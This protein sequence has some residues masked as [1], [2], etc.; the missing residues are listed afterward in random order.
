MYNIQTN[1]V[2]DALN[3][4]KVGLSRDEVK[5][6]QEKNGKNKIDEPK[7]KS[8]LVRFL[9]QFT[10]III[11]VLL[12][13]CVLSVA[14]CIINKDP[15]QLFDAGVILLV[16]IVNAVIGYVQEERA[17]R[18][19]DSLKD[20][21]KPYCKV[22]RDGVVKKIKTEDLV[23]GDVVVLEAGD[24]VPADM[25][26]F[27][28][29][30]LRCNESA[31]TGESMP[32]E[33]H[34]DV[35]LKD[36]V[37]LGDR[38][39]MA[40]MGTSVT[41][42]RGKGVVVAT[43][44]NTEMGKIAD[45]INEQVPQVSPITRRIKKTN[46]YITAFVLVM[47][48]IIFGF[49]IF[50][51]RLS[52]SGAFMMAIAIAVCVIP[53]G[54]PASITVTL[55]IGVSRMSKRKAIV[56]HTPAVETLGSTQ[57][58]CTDKT[59]T[60]TLNEMTVTQIYTLNNAVNKLQSTSE[61]I[62][63]SKSTDISESKKV[64]NL[65]NSQ[66]QN[67]VQ[68]LNSM[69]LCNDTQC[70]Y[71]AGNLVTIGDPTETA[72]VHYGYGLGLNKEVYDAT[73]PRVD[74]V[75]FDSNRKL[76]STINKHDNLYY[77]HT[78]GGVDRLLPICNR[79]LDETGVVRNITASDI[80][81]I[82]KA[83]VDMANDALRVLGFAYREISEDYA[84]MADSDIESNLIFVGLCGMIDP[85][86]AEVADAIK[87]C[88]RAGI[89]T[90]M[91]TGDHKDTAFAIAKK[92]GMATDERQVISGIELDN[93][94]DDEFMVAVKKYTVF[95]RVTPEHKLKIVRAL[96]AQDKIVAMTGDGVNDAPSIKE[97]DIGIGMGITGTD[98]T[99]DV[100]DVILTDDNFAT[101]VSAVEEGRRVYSNIL[102]ILIFLIGTSVA[103]A[104]LLTTIMV[105]MRQDFFTPALI[106][107]INFI[108]DTL[109][110]LALSAEN[111][112]P[113]IMRQKPERHRKSLF[114]GRV[115]V[116]ILYSAL[117]SSIINFAVYFMGLHVF[118]FSHDV[119]ITMCFVTLVFTELFHA[120]NLR[121]DHESVF[122]I[123]VFKNKYMNISFL[124]SATLTTLTVVLPMTTVHAFLGVTQLNIAQWGISLLFAFS[125]VPLMELSKF[126]TYVIKL[127]KANRKPK[128]I[129][130]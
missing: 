71:D 84:N 78:K 96:K 100:A 113:D 24:V 83:N 75:P 19:M 27:E 20:L 108:S 77:V 111:S 18:A 59:G 105:F 7:K 95:A 109:V 130:K 6:R 94:N 116:I 47:A 49:G 90:I 69:L 81:K 45:V 42:G 32:V 104:I 89:S 65:L 38:Y 16:V 17:E 125:I 86:R 103:E 25:R 13:S 34:S 79:I 48:G 63:I 129:I 120:Y 50:D 3:S 87:K 31:L 52:I 29:A 66:S 123:G 28:C 62:N 5:L 99:K 115:G 36:N 127:I 72:L 98:V 112:E 73:Y 110:A 76:M 2:F 37:S 85:P 121:S 118:G 88:K 46:K 91:I 10:D 58:I 124:I 43:G 4:S 93:L 54:L 56:K 23:V 114:A 60:L 106:L 107:W 44:M 82:D 41:I 70:R 53:E 33:K 80:E 119:V 15:E 1:K 57:V 61:P 39:N 8:K 122:K 97:A 64:Q 68:L 92:L 21:T 74:E 22:V 30:N 102:K 26:L 126:I 11:I 117:Y 55:A 12:I 9:M 101:I 67:L 51:P 35:I 14:L 128:K 40:Y